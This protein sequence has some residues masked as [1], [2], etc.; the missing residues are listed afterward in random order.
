LS[1]IWA[2]V[3][4]FLFMSAPFFYHII[5]RDLLEAGHPSPKELVDKIVAFNNCW[6]SLR[7]NLKN[8]SERVSEDQQAML[9]L[10]KISIANLRDIKARLQIQLLRHPSNPAHL[11]YDP[12]VKVEECYTVE[13]KENISKRRD[14]CH[15]PIRVA[16]RLLDSTELKR[17]CIEDAPKCAREE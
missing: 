5:W 9:Q 2:C 1:I 6:H 15:L 16:Q 11:R 10:L 12:R 17:F 3:C 8:E 14:A 4:F 7:D 13:L